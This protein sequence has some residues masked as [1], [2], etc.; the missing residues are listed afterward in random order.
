MSSM[1]QLV[2]KLVDFSYKH[3]P[4][5][6]MYDKEY[7][8]AIEAHLEY[9]TIDY[10]IKEGEIKGFVRYNI[11][12]D[13]LVVE[14]LIIDKDVNGLR[15]IR[16]FLLNNW[17]RYPYVDEVIFERSRKYPHRER[18][19]KFKDIL[20]TKFTKKSWRNEEWEA[21]SSLAQQ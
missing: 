12:E 4:N 16:Y 15:L 7:R 21:Y 14:D 5:L 9:K 11:F 13:Q 20:H 2:D 10:Y 19:Y 8:E 17:M 18:I 1:S 3:D 6:R